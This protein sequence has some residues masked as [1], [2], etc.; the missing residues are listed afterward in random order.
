[1]AHLSIAVRL[2]SIAQ[3][4]PG[5][6]QAAPLRAAMAKA[7]QIGARAVQIDARHDIR[8]S[9]LSA[10]GVR[11]LRK[12][13]D[14]FDLRVAS[15]RFQ[16]RRGYDSPEDLSRRIDATKAAM[17]MAYKLG[18]K[19]VVNQVGS[20]PESK[21]DP[22]YQTLAAVM[23][24]LGRFGAH[25]GA[26]FAAETGTEPGERLAGLLDQD[27]ASYVAVALNP[28]KLVV[29]RFDVQA[30]IRALGSRIQ[31]VIAVDGVVDLAAGRGITVPVGQGTADFPAILAAL[32]DYP[33]AGYVVVGDETP[34]PTSLE[35][36][37]RA[38]QY[39]QNLY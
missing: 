13:L 21:D 3:Q 7:S 5:K 18:A 2:N 9:E 16:T 39:L 24:E 26:F 11:Q 17:E 14:D 20:V 31:T 30:A 32:E 27:D 23:A 15:V 33:F 6:L 38:I 19:L 25:V 22:R 1:M 28:G 12:M 4:S 35:A 29:N 37:A 10:T 36:A 34:A 8:P